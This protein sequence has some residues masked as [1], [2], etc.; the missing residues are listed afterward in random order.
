MTDDVKTGLPPIARADARLFILGSLPG[1]ASLAAQQ[2]YAHPHNQF[3]RLIGLVVGEDLHQLPY[4]GRLERL[5]EHRIGLWDVIGSAVRRG[6]LDQA[7]RDANHNRIEHL[8]HDFAD[9]QAVAFNGGTSAAIG[10]KLIGTGHALSLIDLPS[11]SPA[12][13]R[14]FAEKAAAWAHLRPFCAPASCAMG[15]SAQDGIDD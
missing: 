3:W 14:P 15:Q 6:S 8:V 4:A 13:T 2:Y 12:N 11:S 7:I 5:A 9:L 1:D 10:R